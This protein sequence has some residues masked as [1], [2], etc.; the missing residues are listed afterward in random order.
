MGVLLS[1]VPGMTWASSLVSWVWAVQSEGKGIF[2]RSPSFSHIPFLPKQW[3]QPTPVPETVSESGCY[4][5]GVPRRPPPKASAL[6]HCIGSFTPLKGKLGWRRKDPFAL[7]L[8]EM[9]PQPALLHNLGLERK[10]WV[11]PWQWLGIRKGRYPLSRLLP[12]LLGP[13]K[14]QENSLSPALTFPVC[15]FIFSH[16]RRGMLCRKSTAFGFR[17]KW[18][19]KVWQL[20]CVAS[21]HSL[22]SLLQIRD[23]NGSYLTAYCEEL[24]GLTY[25]KPLKQLLAYSCCSIHLLFLCSWRH[26]N[27]FH[28]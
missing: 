16:G 14:D 4:G 17:R 12:A 2:L 15:F 13:R 22:T 23:N 5:N 19:S 9:L 1:H 25:K 8:K 18:R 7:I 6:P 28:V 26:V 10:I 11:E 27:H 3:A 21:A 20:P 24:D